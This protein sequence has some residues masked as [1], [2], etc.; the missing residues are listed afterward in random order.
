MLNN[1][2]LLSVEEKQK[3]QRV[4]VPAPV[5]PTAQIYW[6]REEPEKLNKTTRTKKTTSSCNTSVF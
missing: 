5:D 6:G 1:S 3:G 4:W 2:R